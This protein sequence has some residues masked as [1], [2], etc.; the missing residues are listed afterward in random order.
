[1]RFREP[2]G[3]PPLSTG[4]NGFRTLD[5]AIVGNRSSIGKRMLA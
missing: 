5:Q 3:D 4:V 1:M 2:F